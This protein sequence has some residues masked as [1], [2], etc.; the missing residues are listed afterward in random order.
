M[1]SAAGDVAAGRAV[2]GG[3]AGEAVPGGAAAGRAVLLAG[4]AGVGKTRLTAEVR[5]AAGEAGWHV[6]QGHCIDF[7]GN[8]LPYLPLSE[9]FAQ[10]PA[11]RVEELLARW[12]ALGRLLPGRPAT[13]G[14]AEPVTGATGADAR[15]ELF[16]A[17][18]STLAHLAADAPVLLVVEDAHWADTST[19]ELL[20]YLLPRTAYAR[21]GVLVT[22]RTD[23]LHRRHPLRQDVLQWSRSDAVARV[24]LRPLPVPAV[25]RL[26]RELQPGAGSDPGAPV[27]EG[28]VEEELVERIVRR[29]QGNPFFVEELVA[30]ARWGERDLSAD[31]VD[32][33]LLRLDQL[34]EPTRTVLRAMS[35]GGPRVSHALLARVLSDDRGQGAVDDEGDGG[36]SGLDAALRQALDRN[37]VVAE[38][39][40]YAFRH[41]LLAEAVYEDLLPG[42]RVRWHRGYVAALQAGEGAGAA[43]ELARHAR[44]A[45]DVATAIAAS[46]RAGEEATAAGGPAEAARHFE[47]ALQLLAEHSHEQPEEEATAL[48]TDLVLR[49]ADSAVAAGLP[50]RGLA[51]LRDAVDAPRPGLDDRQ[52]A[53]LLHA[54]ARTAMLLDAPVDALAITSRALRLPPAAE[55]GELRARLLATHALAA[56]DWGRDE[57]AARWAREAAAL[58]QEVGLPAVLADATTT[59]ARLSGL[60]AGP[61]VEADLRRSIA[62]GRAAGDASAELRSAHGLGMVLYEAGRL[63]E[64]QEAYLHAVRRARELHRPWAPYGVDSRVMAGLVAYARGDWE[65]VLRVTAVDDEQPPGALRAVLASVRLM[66]LA[67]R[68][69]AAGLAVVEELRPWWV[70]DVLTAI[71]AA[72]GGIDLIGS[73]SGPDPAAD[74]LDE[75]VDAVEPLLG[76][77]VFSARIRLGALL[78]GQ[79]A[80]AALAGSARERERLASA[81]ELVVAAVEEAAAAAPRFGPESVAWLAR[82]RAEHARLLHAAGRSGDS[83]T[84]LVGLWQQ[85]L[86]A[87]ER[88]GHVPE[89]ARSR[90][91]LAAALRAA[92]RAGEAAVEAAAALAVA[93]RLGAR[94]LVAELRAGGAA[95]AGEPDDPDR[96]TA[97]ELEVLALVS[98]GLTNREVG[99][100]LFISAKTVSVHVSNAMAKLQAGSRNEAAYVARRRG[101]LP[102]A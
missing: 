92:G 42:E 12:P 30:A 35:V 46:V 87:M 99:E 16:D 11:Q 59:L 82:A 50:Q 78:L 27:K 65:E 34:D 33:L 15:A 97:R 2:P 24:Q 3:A 101:L 77:R 71:N 88:F 91:R 5:R 98:Q 21:L 66:V 49:A 57:D 32:L 25:R 89:T 28:L 17:V 53:L 69:D 52:L 58:A 80:S 96:L 85:A 13:G 75:V 38:G 37:L 100:A 95:P 56:L 64:A 4:E 40:G 29:A 68:G 1:G 14:S 79:Y 74:L 51:L 94:P 36:A 45:G 8:T 20:S 39:G 61:E 86:A 10:L 102:S 9:A 84:A 90:A 93:E 18:W 31:L 23:D 63:A 81:G 7:G 55:P 76:T 62:E 6:L 60:S 44:G 47:N 72:A 83:A 67:G 54:T 43:A 73:L 22:Y 48:A 41:A 26:V 70:H 19:R